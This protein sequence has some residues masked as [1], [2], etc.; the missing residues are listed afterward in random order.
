[1]R[2][3]ASRQ[4]NYITHIRAWNKLT[5]YGVIG[6]TMESHREHKLLPFT[7]SQLF[8]IVADVANY[9]RFIPW[10]QGARVQK[11]GGQFIIADLQ[12]GFG[13]FHESFT[14]HV[15]LDRPREV[16]VHS[17]SGP[18]EHLS[19]RWTFTPAQDATRVDFAV[20]FQFKSHLLNHAAGAMFHEASKRM[21]EAF[22]TRAH[23][24]YDTS[25][26]S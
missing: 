11:T 6:V 17:V 7:A 22:R 10:C 23:A 19:N 21:M 5:A 3:V 1:M 2:R 26:T 4:P 25:S 20:D 8:D 16:I 15:E 24:L 12:I 18:L 14:S 9:P 13:P